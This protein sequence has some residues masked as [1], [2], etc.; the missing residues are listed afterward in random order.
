MCACLTP[1][2]R[3]DTQYQVEN[4]TVSRTSRT[5]LIAASGR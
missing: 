4:C 5:M 3:Y 2:S 1:G